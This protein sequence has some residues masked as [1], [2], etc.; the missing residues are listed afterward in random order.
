MSNTAY[1]KNKD[2]LLTIPENISVLR[3]QIFQNAQQFM[4]AAFWHPYFFTNF[5]ES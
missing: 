1:L 2:T 3:K 4:G 5:R